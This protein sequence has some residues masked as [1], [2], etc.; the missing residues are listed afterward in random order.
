VAWCQLAVLLR[1]MPVMAAGFMQ[2]KVPVNAP[3]PVLLDQLVCAARQNGLSP[4]FEKYL[5]AALLCCPTEQRAAWPVSVRELAGRCLPGADPVLLAAADWI[6]VPLPVCQ[7]SLGRCVWMLAAL[8][9]AFQDCRCLAPPVPDRE[10]ET[11]ITASVRYREQRLGCM[12]WFLQEADDPAVSGDSLGLTMAL[13]VWQLQQG[14]SWPSGVY[15]TGALD[16]SGAV[17]PVTGIREKYQAVR[18]DCTLFLLPFSSSAGISTEQR[19]YSCSSFDDAC[20]AIDQHRGVCSLEQIALYQSCL[21]NPSELLSHFHQ[22]PLSLLRQEPCQLLLNRLAGNPEQYLAQLSAALQQC[23]HDR[24]YGHFL[25]RLVPASETVEIGSRSREL[26]FAAFEWSLACVGYYNHCGQG[27]NSEQWIN[28]AE[29]LADQVGFSEQSKLMNH[30]FVSQRFN[31]YHFQV[32]LPPEF[33]RFLERRQKVWD[34]TGDSDYLLGSLYGTLA[35][36]YGF[37]GSESES[38]LEKMCDRAEQAF[39]RKYHGEKERLL[40]YRLYSCLDSGSHERAAGLLTRYLVTGA[41]PDSWWSAV[42]K[43]LVHGDDNALFKIAVALRVMVATG[44]T[45]HPD[46]AGCLSAKVL[47]AQNS[48]HPWQLIALNFAR[49][50]STLQPE[51]SGLTEELLR[52][53]LSI[54]LQDSDTALRPMALLALAEL[55]RQGMASRDDYQQAAEIRDWLGRTRALHRQ[56]FISILDQTDGVSLLNRVMEQ[57]RQLFPFSYR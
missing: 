57:R 39:G 43:L 12:Y 29:S 2:G 28:C 50:L 52:H 15:A 32:T 8:T 26:A 55:H 47:I 54:C 36:N 42:E 21:K 33:S 38:E 4:V 30:A 45:P 25:V 23:G 9:D 34:L 24:E 10:T 53:S 41:D 11:E 13:A 20:F 3:D 22:L 37:C 40:N 56:H 14:R 35:Q 31:R 44:C 7:G 27:E 6:Q 1:N 51:Q 48:A 18:H 5:L 46:T 49:L 16:C 17:R 19:L